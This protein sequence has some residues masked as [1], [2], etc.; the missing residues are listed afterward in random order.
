MADLTTRGIARRRNCT[1]WLH[2]TIDAKRITQPGWI[3]IPSI[4]PRRVATER[5]IIRRVVEI[6]VIGAGDRVRKP[7]EGHDQIIYAARTNVILRQ[8]HVDVA[9][10]RWGSSV[11]DG[12]SIDADRKRVVAQCVS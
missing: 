10:S 4:T 6:R 7:R 9:G 11:H 12:V 2:D 1:V 3:V 5:Q 8:R